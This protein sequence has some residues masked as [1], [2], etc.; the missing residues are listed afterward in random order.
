MS[1]RGL[2]HAVFLFFLLVLVSLFLSAFLYTCF[3]RP[4]PTPS[5][6]IPQQ[7]PVV[8]V[9]EK[10]VQQVEQAPLPSIHIPAI[11]V[12]AGS[13][14]VERDLV[15]PKP[16][17]PLKHLLSFRIFLTQPRDVSNQLQPRRHVCP[18][19][20]RLLLRR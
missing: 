16:L 6:P 17:P 3:T 9:P 4:V 2:A 1:K 15:Q 14:H 20:R 18:A 5:S 12:F 8:A 19:S 13:P 11:P 7:I 10:Q